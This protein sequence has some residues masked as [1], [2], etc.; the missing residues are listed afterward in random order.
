MF[1]PV[2]PVARCGNMVRARALQ[3]FGNASWGSA[4]AFFSPQVRCILRIPACVDGFGDMSLYM[5]RGP[6][7]RAH[8]RL[9]HAVMPSWCYA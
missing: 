1:K 4:S 7:R 9:L 2:Q 6:D 3:E 8:T 5:A